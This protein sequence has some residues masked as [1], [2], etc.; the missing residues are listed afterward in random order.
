MD[1]FEFYQTP[2]KEKIMDDKKLLIRISGDLDKRT[3]QEKRDD[4]KIKV[5]R[6]DE[7]DA[8]KIQIGI[9]KS[10]KFE[11]LPLDRICTQLQG[12]FKNLEGLSISSIGEKIHHIPESICGFPKLRVLCLQ[13]PICSLPENLGSLTNLATFRLDA[14]KMLGTSP[15]PLPAAMRR[16]AGILL[17]ESMG[18]LVNFR[19]LEFTSCN[20]QVMPPFISRQSNL[21][22]LTIN[23]SSIREIPERALSGTM[24]ILTMTNSHLESLPESIGSLVR[25]NTLRLNSNRLTTLPSSIGNLT[26]LKTLVLNN[27][28]LTTLP[29]TCRELMSLATLELNNNQLTTLPAI[30]LPLLKKLDLSHNRITVLPDSIGSNL[31][32]DDEEDEDDDEKNDQPRYVSKARPVE[33]LNLSHNNLTAIPASFGNLR[34][35]IVLNLSHNPTLRVLP[36]EVIDLR[37]P[38]PRHRP[39]DVNVVGTGINEQHQIGPINSVQVHKEFAKIDIRSLFMFIDTKVPKEALEAERRS[40][41][42]TRV[43]G[44]LRSYIVR[45][46]L[47][48]AAQKH[49]LDNLSEIYSQRLEGYGYDAQDKTVISY[50]MAYVA[51]QPERFQC[52]YARAFV[53][54]CGYAAYGGL[55]ISCVKGVIERFVSTLGLAALLYDGTPEYNSL[56]YRQLASIIGHKKIGSLKEHM[57]HISKDCYAESDGDVAKFRKCIIDK[58]KAEL[59]DEFNEKNPTTETTLNEVVKNLGMFDGGRVRRTHKKRKDIFRKRT[60]KQKG[61]RKIRSTR[62]KKRTHKRSH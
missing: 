51:A 7:L 26:I 5:I 41:D 17:P 14:Q 1:L 55:E 33:F 44:T 52:E 46:P 22:V 30:E 58:L 50:C 10:K 3:A 56:Q 23:D 45:M 48:Q 53:E 57:Y 47:N 8:F 37:A 36:Q 43:A 6:I 11:V 21:Q 59:G 2:A 12:R 18:A 27:N 16:R 42:I 34:N 62:S 38:G 13:G 4:D 49:L 24:N 19:V 32:D 28:Q 54:D 60:I 31:P 20:L 40:V 25:L 29:D 9:G 15:V 35:L 61:K 39:T